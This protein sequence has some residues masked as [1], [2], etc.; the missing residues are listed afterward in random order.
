VV[1]VEDYDVVEVCCEMVVACVEPQVCDCVVSGF[2][3][4]VFQCS[5]NVLPPCLVG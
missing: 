1:E 2:I 3:F 4:V 5:F